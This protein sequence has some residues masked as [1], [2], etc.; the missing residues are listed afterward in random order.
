MTKQRRWMQSAI[1]TAATAE[2]SFP[3]TRKKASRHAATEASSRQAQSRL[4]N[5]GLTAKIAAR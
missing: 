2:V 1:A 5:Y 4:V 3:W